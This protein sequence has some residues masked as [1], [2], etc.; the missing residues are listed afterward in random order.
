MEQWTFGRVGTILL[1]LLC[2]AH[3]SIAHAAK[4]VSAETGAAETTRAF[5]VA[6][7]TASELP[8]VS[9]DALPSAPATPPP[10]ASPTAG[11]PTPASPAPSAVPDAVP[12]TEDAAPEPVSR[13]WIQHTVVPGERL[14][15]IAIRYDVSRPELI[16]WNK[17][18]QGKAYIYAGRKLRIYARALPPPRQKISY[19]VQRGDTWSGIAS[20]FGVRES[21]VRFWNQKKVK[22]LR[23]GGE[24][25]IFTNPLQPPAPPES[26]QEPTPVFHARAGGMSIGLPNHGRLYAGVQLAKSDLYSI[27]NPDEA[28]GS[29]HTVDVLVNSIIKFRET[30]GYRGKLEIRAMSKERGGYFKPHRSHQSGRDIDIRLP[31]LPSAVERQQTDADIDWAASWELIKAFAGSGEVEYIFLAYP[32]QRRLYAAAQTAGASNGELKTLIQFPRRPG[33]NHGLVR[34]AEGHTIHIHVRVRC[35]KTNDRC[36]TY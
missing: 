31:L 7:P 26:P 27:R 33:S 29:T 8:G 5:G 6:P 35:S 34:H 36:E 3:S 15:D 14:D 2:V 16:R 1:A 21:D 25:L 32:Q 20:K 12:A 11:P 10:L 22:S 9:P 30:S 18:L 24:L 23:A 19:R 17:S 4:A 28:W 13:K